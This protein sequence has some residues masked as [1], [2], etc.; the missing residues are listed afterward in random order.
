MK[1]NQLVFFLSG[2]PLFQAFC[3]DGNLL[4]ERMY[5]C[6]PSRR[7]L[8]CGR[9]QPFYR[10]ELVSI[11]PTFYEQLY[12][13]RSPKRKKDCQVKQLLALMGFACVKAARRTLVKLTPRERFHKNNHLASLIWIRDTLCSDCI[14]DLDTLNLIW[15]FDFRIEKICDIA[16]AALKHTSSHL[17]VVKSNQKIII[18]IILTRL[19]LNLW[20]TL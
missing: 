14:R 16:T 5:R 7:P 6:R 8:D 13:L 3:L 9:L 12:L 1:T 18:S 10:G 15:R 2:L 4:A 17:K 19:S 20:D 11:S